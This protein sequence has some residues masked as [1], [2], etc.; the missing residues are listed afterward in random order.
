MTA[1]DDMT[2]DQDAAERAL[3]RRAALPATAAQ[4]PDPTD[5]AAF[6]DGAASEAQ[7]GRVEAWLASDPSAASELV[8]MSAPPAVVLGLSAGA[9]RRAKRLGGEQEAGFALFANWRLGALTA[10]CAALA[11]WAGVGLGAGLHAAQSQSADRLAA[12]A[13]FGDVVDGDQS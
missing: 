9:R 6:L 5:L 7:R 2:P 10:A 12:Q 1:E 13:L 3:W 11:I 8:E 4:R